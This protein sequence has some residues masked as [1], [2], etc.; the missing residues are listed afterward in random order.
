MKK[1]AIIII[2][3]VAFVL[4][5][6]IIRSS[7]AESEIVNSWDCTVT[8]A[9]EASNDTYVITYCDDKIVSTTGILTLEN[10][11]DFGIVVYLKAD[12]YERIELMD[13]DSRMILYELDKEVEY[14]VGFHASVT[15]GTEITLLVYDGAVNISEHVPLWKQPISSQEAIE[16]AQNWVDEKSKKRVTNFE[17]PQTIGIVCSKKFLERIIP[18]NQNTVRKKKYAGREIYRITFRTYDD[19]LLGPIVI[20]VDKYTGDLVGLNPRF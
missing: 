18:G 11:N 9:E 12:D 2:A 20:Y 17:N 10:N 19:G 7:K 13:A 4:G 8:Y 3:L 6:G 16:I 1:K 14:A 15:R 5:I